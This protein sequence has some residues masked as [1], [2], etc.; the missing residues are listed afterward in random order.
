M[1][2][3][4]KPEQ[5]SPKRTPPE[6]Q[7]D[8]DRAKRSGDLRD[9]IAILV[10][11]AIIIPIVVF[12]FINFYGSD[13]TGQQPPTPPIA[14]STGGP[15]AAIVDHLALT[16]PNA[17]FAETATELLEQAG[18]AVDYFPG[19][20]VTV[21]FYRYLPTW[22]HEFIILRV[23]SALG[24]IGD[25][26][27]DWVTLFTSDPYNT[28]SYRKDQ[29]KQRLSKVSYYKDGPEYFGVM[30]GFIKSSIKSDFQDA[31]IIIMGCDGL[32]T[33]SMAEAFVERGAKAVV[34]WDGL[35]SSEHTDAA[36][37]RLLQHLLIDG[38]PLQQA[39]TQTMAEV[40]PDPLYESTLLLY[41][42]EEPDSA[43]P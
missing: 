28:T 18:Y 34:A 43:T 33:D 14:D 38:L 25:Q 6:A 26:M 17:A 9:K 11:A 5:R 7:D 12:T 42:S 23:H 37:E 19:E 40:G 41:P 35:V 22:G 30:P 13:E 24:R 36:T 2:R 10:A 1:N 3:N 4:S 21:E 15:R 27:A 31:T 20:E 29:T 39:V 8:A 32:S 16:Q